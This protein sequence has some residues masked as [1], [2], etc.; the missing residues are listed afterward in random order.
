M[1][2]KKLSKGF[3]VDVNGNL[4]KEFVF[5]AKADI[6]YDELRPYIQNKG[7]IG[8]LGIF[9]VGKSTATVVRGEKMHFIGIGKGTPDESDIGFFREILNSVERSFDSAMESRIR[10]AL[11]AEQVAKDEQTAAKKSSDELN[12]N[13][14]DLAL[15]GVALEELRMELDRLKQ[16]TEKWQDELRDFETQVNGRHL[17]INE[18]VTLLLEREQG[19]ARNQQAFEVASEAKRSLVRKMQTE[20]AHETEQL[21]IAFSKLAKENENLAA[22]AKAYAVDLEA[23]NLDKDKWEK[24]SKELKVRAEALEES[25]KE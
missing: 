4:V 19:L 20:I 24:E 14:N 21:E 9:D 16:E 15:E 12:M 22:R 18:R 7:D 6:S 17:Q 5:S 10:Q 11:A 1:F 23:L 25:K 8:S 3:L 2:G 13:R